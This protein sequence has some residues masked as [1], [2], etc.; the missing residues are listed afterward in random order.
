MVLAGERGCEAGRAEASHDWEQVAVEIPAAAGELR[1]LGQS[2]VER[3]RY[4]TV[5]C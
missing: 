5:V 1:P 4:L 2:D 3:Q